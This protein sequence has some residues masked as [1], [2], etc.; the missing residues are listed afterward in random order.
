MTIS[1]SSGSTDDA[2]ELTVSSAGLVTADVVLSTDGDLVVVLG[3]CVVVVVATGVV[4]GA[5]VLLGVVTGSSL[6]VWFMV[7]ERGAKVEV[8]VVVVVLVIL[9]VMFGWET[10]ESVPTAGKLASKVVK[11]PSVVTEGSVNKVEIGE[12][13][14]SWIKVG[15]PVERAGTVEI[16][17]GD[18]VVFKSFSAFGCSDETGWCDVIGS[19]GVA[20][21][22][23]M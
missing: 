11:A 8:V 5:S 17:E 19:I 13:D 14:S 1:V 9:V 7:V 20:E 4:V 15:P 10:G 23:S 2:D 3:E 22:E 16:G 21:D 18:V 6:V 12:D